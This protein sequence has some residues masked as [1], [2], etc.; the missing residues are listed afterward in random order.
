MR[1]AYDPATNTI[2]DLRIDDTALT[3]ATSFYDYCFRVLR[4]DALPPFSRQLWMCVMLLQEFCPRCS[5][6]KWVESL[7]I[8][9]VDM[10][11]KDLI[12]KIAILENGICPY[13]GTSKSQLLDSK[14]LY[15]VNELVMIAGQ[16][17]GKCVSGD[18]SV[19]TSNGV[20]TFTAIAKNYPSTPGFHP[21]TGSEKFVD[22]TG[23]LVKPSH[24]YVEKKT[25]IL[26]ATTSIGNSIT[27]TT[28]HPLWTMSGWKNLSDLSAGDEIPVKVGQ[29]VWGSNTSL[30]SYIEAGNQAF[31]EKRNSQYHGHAYERASFVATN[32]TPQISALLGLWIAE[33]HSGTTGAGFSI[34]NYDVGVLNFC[35]DT[36]DAIAPGT[37]THVGRTNLSSVGFSNLKIASIFDAMLDNQ[38]SNKSR[39]ADKFIPKLILGAPKVCVVAFLKALY[40]GDGGLNGRN[41]DYTTISPV[42]A[43][44]VQVL[45]LNLGIFASLREFN[46]WASNGTPSQVSKKGYTVRVTG[47]SC[48]KLFSEK[49]GFF[50]SRKK[51]ALDRSLHD[52][53]VDGKRFNA[54]RYDMF[55]QSYTEKIIS[56]YR[57]ADQEISMYGETDCLN[58]YQSFSLRRFV[59]STK[60]IFNRGKTPKRA[61]E[62]GTCIGRGNNQ[63]SRW[64]VARTVTDLKASAGWPLLSKATQA[65]LETLKVVAEDRTLYWVTVKSVVS[66]PKAVTYDVCIP[67]GHRFMANGLLNHNSSVTAML[68]TYVTHLL[69]KSPRLSSILPGIQAFTPLSLTVVATTAGQAIKTLWSPIRKIVAASSWYGEYHAMLDE[70][71]ESRGVPDLY[72]F[73][74]TTGLYIRYGHKNLELYSS[75]PAKRTLRGDTRYF[76]ATDE[77]GLF[78]FNPNSDSEG[79]DEERERANADEVYQSLVNSLTTVQAGV[80]A[81]RKKGIN[82]LPNAINCNISSP[83]SW[84][85]KICRL[86]EEAEDNPYTVRLKQP[87][88]EISPLYQRDHP[89][90]VSLYRKNPKKAERDF[91]ANPPRMGTDFYN[92]VSVTKCFYGDNWY[93]IVYDYSHVD[94]Q[95]EAVKVKDVIEYPASVMSLDAGINNNAFSLTL[96]NRKDGKIIAPVTLEI[97]PQ[98]GKDL[99]YPSIYEKVIKPI[100]RD[101]NVKVLTADRFNSI[102]VL[103]QARDDFPELIVGQYSVKLS[104]FKN[105]ANYIASESIVFP[106]LEMEVSRIKVVRD[107]KSELMNAPASHLFL[108]FLT[109]Q[110]LGGTVVKGQGQGG[111]KYTDDIHRALVLGVAV[112]FSDKATK[113]LAKYKAKGRSTNIGQSRVLVSG[114]MGQPGSVRGRNY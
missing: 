8:V 11:P 95:A 50:T 18:T 90:I 1:K 2:R 87:T 5:K 71:S 40:E 103:Q 56:V 26:T 85:D 39:S 78:P 92:E 3:M 49:L 84:M 22:E 32:L 107:Y 17:S 38:I 9:P 106:T 73:N 104:D 98:Q 112:L 65:D 23:K 67:E 55:P 14:L 62:N 86:Y 24:F 58:R 25:K 60:R 105:M 76:A 48:R 83:F 64:L 101:C 75:G 114:R 30:A 37:L 68:A 13:C 66:E 100:I 69:L 97:V 28:N 21:Y 47:N 110:E 88:W 99:H 81:G 91:G 15:E 29:D 80:T 41:I 89:V 79:E 82:H 77:L 113:H 43:K 10:D 63:V 70:H 46:T 111:V 57:A 6:K 4:G 54:S 16:R 102:Q 94:L 93:R 96:V 31:T 72:S 27:G 42:L 52:V 61:K 19:L 33:G 20:T 109:V 45:L 36:L 53:G 51:E 108:Q 12:K 44:Q 59:A 7:D 35:R 74:P 34:S